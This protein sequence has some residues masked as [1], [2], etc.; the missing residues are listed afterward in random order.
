[1]IIGKALF[2]LGSILRAQFPALNSNRLHPGPNELPVELSPTPRADG[3]IRIF[4][5]GETLKRVG[6]IFRCPRAGALDDG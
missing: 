2:V 3:L 6:N 5:E 4:I 1:M